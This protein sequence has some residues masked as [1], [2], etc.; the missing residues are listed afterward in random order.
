LLSPKYAARVS[1][2]CS[3]AIINIQNFSTKTEKHTHTRTPKVFNPHGGVMRLCAVRA[4]IL[5]VNIFGFDFV[6]YTKKSKQKI[7][8]FFTN[9]IHPLLINFRS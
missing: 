3:N 9:S 2:L 8:I 6:F 1:G 4:M 5:E 7:L